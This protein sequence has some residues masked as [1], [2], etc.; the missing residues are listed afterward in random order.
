ML[1][2]L[3][4]KILEDAV[5]TS[6]ILRH[7]L[8]MAKHLDDQEVHDWVLAE[9]HGYKSNKE[10]LVLPAYRKFDVES[11]GYFSCGVKEYSNLPIPPHA[12]PESLKKIC[13]IAEIF[14]SIPEIELL[15]SSKSKNPDADKMTVSNWPADFLT[16]L[17]KVYPKYVCLKAWRVIPETKLF[18]I[19]DA[20]KNKSLQIILNLIDQGIVVDVAIDPTP[21]QKRQFSNVFETVV[22]GNIGVLQVGETN[23]ALVDISIDEGNLDQLKEFLLDNGIDDET[24]LRLSVAIENDDR[25]VGKRVK[26]WLRDTRDKINRGAIKLAKGVTFQVLL[27]AILKYL[28]VPY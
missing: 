1:E 3:K 10:V 6:S 27:S 14:E 5:T 9:L 17:D 20:V 11:F 23:N 26:E 7:F 2:N 24:F 13:C 18:G 8:V 22:K 25:N 4:N 21:E 16:L 28:G 19:V 15:M 12:V